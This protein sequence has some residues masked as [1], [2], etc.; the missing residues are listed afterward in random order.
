MAASRN[1]IDIEIETAENFRRK[2]LG[3]MVGAKL[4]LHC[5][6]NNIKPKWLAANEDSENLALRLG[7]TK[8]EYYETFQINY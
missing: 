6:Q 4:V 8:G 3:T 5:I 1:A 2:G 7:F